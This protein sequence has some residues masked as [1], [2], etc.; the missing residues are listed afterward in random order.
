[1]QGM[2]GPYL[3]FVILHTYGPTAGCA[4]DIK[5]SLMTYFIE[6][7]CSPIGFCKN[8]DKTGNEAVQCNVI[9]K[10]Y[11]AWGSLRSLQF[12]YQERQIPQKVT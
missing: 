10:V 4:A 12:Y 6:I 2:I 8:S 1:M 3:Q 5:R 11:M 7:S 9:V